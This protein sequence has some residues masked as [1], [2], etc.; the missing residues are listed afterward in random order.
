M[1]KYTL[2]INGKSSTHH[3]YTAEMA[4]RSAMCWYMTGTEFSVID[5]NG[6]VSR[7][8]KVSADDFIS[9]YCDLIEL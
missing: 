7:F 9:G 8:K 4:V 3:A 6:N 2:V 5:S 1:N